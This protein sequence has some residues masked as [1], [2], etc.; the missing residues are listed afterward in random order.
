MIKI[1]QPAM[2]IDSPDSVGRIAMCTV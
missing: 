2:A 1:N